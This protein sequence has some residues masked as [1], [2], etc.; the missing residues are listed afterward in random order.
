MKVSKRQL[1]RI[2]QEEKVKL[3]ELDQVEYQSDEWHQAMDELREGLVNVVTAAMD[4]G[5]LDDDLNDAWADTK[6]M[7]R[8]M[9][10]A[11]GEF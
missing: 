9:L 5:L 7:I 4:V 2:I 6:L 11:S 8:D 3:Q 1:R 10:D